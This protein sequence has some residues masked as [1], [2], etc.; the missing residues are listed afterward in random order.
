MQ[1]ILKPVLK[2]FGLHEWARAL[3]RNARREWWLWRATR[4]EIQ[5]WRAAGCPVPAPSAIKRDHLRRYAREWGLKVLVETGTFHGDTPFA[6]RNQFEAIHSI[7]LSPEMH[8]YAKQRLDHLAHIHLYQGDSTVLLPQ[9]TSGLR[10]P[11]LFWL[12]GHYCFG[13]RPLVDKHTPIWEEL[14]HLLG[15]EAGR[16]VILVDDARC[17]DGTNDYPTLEQ[18]RQLVAKHR[19]GAAFVVEGD[20][21][22]IHPV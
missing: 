18:L 7:E 12:D 14:V 13:P 9:I 2:W 5:V 11:T 1:N 3:N 16:D 8:A 20:I 17:F 15:R 19:P 6:L 22:R 21:I 10:S 4:A